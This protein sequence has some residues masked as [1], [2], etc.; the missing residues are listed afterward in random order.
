MAAFY[1]MIGMLGAYLFI[2]L[3]FTYVAHRVPREPVEDAPDWG[4]L[5]D[6]RIP[7]AGGGSLEIWRVDP[8]GESRGIVLLAHGW[9]RNR[10]RMVSRARLFGRMGFTTVIHSARDHGGS[11]PY[12]FM[13]AMRFAED[14]DAVIDWVGEPVLLYGHS[15]GAAGAAICSN[16][17]PHLIRLLFLEGCYPRTKQ[18]LRGLYR[19]YNK[20][21]G[22]AFGPMVVLWMD[23]FY[24]FRMDAVSPAR[25]AAKIE[26]PVLVIHGEQD[27][28]FPLRLAR[29]LKDS[30]P[31]G[32]AE[33]FLGRGA[34]HS[35]SSLAPGYAEAVEAFVNRHL[36]KGPIRSRDYATQ[37]RGDPES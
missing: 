35:G 9:G 12:R 36:P 22:L 24:G 8:A 17:R 28:R 3:V 11:T 37:R 5:T 26:A 18:A 6:A 16:R 27:Q 23:I 31:P 21:L 32:R 2:S 33:F 20:V 19:S 34:D 29:Q 1:W 10:D 4:G 30:F 13:N 7:S 25:L 15:A 14:I